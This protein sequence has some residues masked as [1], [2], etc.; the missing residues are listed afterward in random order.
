M[1]CVACG[2]VRCCE[3]VWCVYILSPP[4]VCMPHH[5]PLPSVLLSSAA[6]TAV[7]AVR[8]PLCCRGRP[9]PPAAVAAT[10][11]RGQRPRSL[12]GCRRWFPLRVGGCHPTAIASERDPLP[13]S[14]SPPTTAHSGQ[15][16]G[17]VCVW[18]CVCGV[19]LWVGGMRLDGSS[20][21]GRCCTQ[22]PYKDR[23]KCK[24]LHS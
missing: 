7:A 23:D 2:V 3:C 5:H 6:C 22:G 16:S 12:F 19:G 15:G 14:S 24:G 11:A 4:S 9:L 18:G 13:H 8:S 20:Q 17:A 1:R 10:P 21:E